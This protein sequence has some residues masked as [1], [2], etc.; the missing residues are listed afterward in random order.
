[1][2]RPRSRCADVKAL[3]PSGGAGT[4][5][6]PITHTSAKQLVPVANKPILFYGLE[7]VADAGIEDVAIVVG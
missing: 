4:R 2:A 1:M 7:S 6:R 3:I 5:L